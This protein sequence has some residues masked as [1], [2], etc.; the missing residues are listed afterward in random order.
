[1][2]FNCFLAQVIAFGSGE[3]QGIERYILNLVM[4]MQEGYNDQQY[5]IKS[6]PIYSNRFYKK[7]H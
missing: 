2:L 6:E 5:P 7:S 3:K 1:M 4:S